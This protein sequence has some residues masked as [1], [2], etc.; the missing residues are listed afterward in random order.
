MGDLG[1]SSGEVADCNQLKRVPCARCVEE[2]KNVNVPLKSQCL[3]CL[4]WATVETLQ[5]AP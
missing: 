3:V 1:A 4:F 2:C 5:P